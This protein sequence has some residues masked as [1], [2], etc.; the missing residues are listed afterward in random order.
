VRSVSWDELVIDVVE[1]PQALP[2]SPRRE[3]VVLPLHPGLL[4]SA[5][6]FIMARFWT[7]ASPLPDAM[8]GK[9]TKRE[10]STVRGV[11]SWR[12]GDCGRYA[13]VLWSHVA[14][15]GAC[16]CLGPIPLL[17]RGE[18]GAS[19]RRPRETQWGWRIGGSSTTSHLE[20][21]SK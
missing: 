8:L 7:S 13:V 1:L 4:L 18:K 5:F 10:K 6:I 19:P 2:G 12:N 20:P 14:S 3:Y 16:R 11:A 17:P 9:P 15:V 21:D